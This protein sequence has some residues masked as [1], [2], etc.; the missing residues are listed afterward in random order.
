MDVQSD[1]M[2]QVV[3]KERPHCLVAIQVSNSKD[4]GLRFA[5]ISRDVKSQLL[6]LLLQTVLRDGVQFVEGQSGV[7]TAERYAFPM[8]V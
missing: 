8:H 4:A 7:L 5:Y 3:G 2:S 6:Q 1:V